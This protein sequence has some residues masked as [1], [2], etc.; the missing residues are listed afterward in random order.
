[1]HNWELTLSSLQTLVDT[2]PG[3]FYHARAIEGALS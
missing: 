1:M 3:H 2:E